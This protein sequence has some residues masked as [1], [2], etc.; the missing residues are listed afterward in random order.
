MSILILLVLLPLLAA[1]GILLGLPA[2][3]TA[4]AAAAANFAL[5]LGV[6]FAYRPAPAGEEGRQTFRFL[7]S[8]P[9]V[10]ELDLKFLVGADG[11]GVMMV[12]LAAIV[13]LS[14][15]WV[16]PRV[17][18]GEPLFYACLLFISA[19]ALGAF[20]SLDLFFFY[21]FH[22]LALIPTFLLIGIYGH[23]EDRL[24]TAWKITIYLAL[25]SF[26]LLIGLIG[27]YLLVP[28]ELRTFDLTKL[29]ALARD[30]QIASGRAQYWP[31]LLMLLGFGTLISLFPFHT[32]APSAYAAAPTPAAML[33]AGVMKKFGL[34]GLLR[35]AVPLLPDGARHWTNLLLILLVGNILYVG[36]VT[37]AQ[38]RLD[39]MLGYSSVMHMGY[40]FLGIAS[41]NAIGMSGA[42]LMMFAHGLS[43]AALFA[44][45]GEIRLRT[46]TLQMSEL[47]GLAKTA[48]FLA[49]AFGLAMFASIGL[50]GFANF[51]SEALV[52]FGAFGS[53]GAHAFRV[54]GSGTFHPGRLDRY[55]VA[56]VCALWGVV[57][58]AVYMLRAYRRTFQGEAPGRETIA[59]TTPAAEA[60][61]RRA[62]V[63]V[64]HGADVAMFRRWPLVLLL[65]T[66]MIVGFAPQHLL[67]KVSPGL[68]ATLFGR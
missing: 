10:P 61:E 67:D 37:I 13:T 55:Q 23:G 40:I 7:A 52:F 1:T 63:A 17:E 50:P 58:S 26:V 15:I 29:Y 56:T 18:R 27:L 38:R 49:L 31:F 11:L 22:E 44:T 9:V 39:L 12:L 5:A 45:L 47:G 60:S 41:L 43:I 34:F 33:H 48:P 53:G 16:S 68:S 20:V 19:G 25:G 59:T 8:V 66:L 24:R 32:W 14:A 64:G 35:V 65:A 62:P 30:G 57:I 21:A 54:D 46:G 4:F 51:A 42:A 3:R 2:R 6:F 36:F 28:L